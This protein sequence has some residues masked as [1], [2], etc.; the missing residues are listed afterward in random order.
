MTVDEAVLSVQDAPSWDARVASIRQ[1]PEQFGT[2]ALQ[3]VYAAIAR[4]VYVPSL[5]PDF[6]YVHWR[7]E[8]ELVVLEA[9]YARASALTNS[10]SR[11]DQGTLQ[12]TLEEA[13][14]TLRIFRL[15]L[16]LT[17]PEFAA[18]TRAL[19]AIDAG[20][21]AITVVSDSRIKSM[22][23]GGRCSSEAAYAC[24]VVID[25]TMRR[26]LFGTSPTSDVRSK[27][28]K[29]DTV[30]GWHS[31]QHFA[32]HGVPLPVFLHQRLYGGAFRQLLDATST[33]R[34]DVVE[35]AV[36][37]LF[38]QH[39]IRHVRTGTHNQE[40]IARRF[41]LTV[42]PAPDFVVCDEGDT[43]RA[44]LECKAANDGGTARD[45]A[46][47]FRSLRTESTRLGGVPLFAV[48]SGL[49]W[50]RASDAMGPVVR[51]TDG[52]TFT[53]PTLTNLL[54]VQPFPALRST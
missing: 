39:G 42:K 3:E 44:I 19:G 27:I 41:Q 16:G 40:E 6:A 47:R 53:L 14:A 21:R 31:V 49:G 25:R 22:E 23:K 50:T 35:D 51:D 1:I 12:R 48:L 20:I 28:D 10:F 7:D 32:A 13:P 29:P 43:L 9:A 46:A 34:G 37:E 30:D 24:S 45:K 26:E 15:L 5:A 18:A 33:R 52:R 11:T 8:Y 38:G 54:S 4:R 36:E 17:V 2:A